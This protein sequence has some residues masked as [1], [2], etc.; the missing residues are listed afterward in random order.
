VAQGVAFAGRRRVGEDGGGPR[1]VGQAAAA[2]AAQ[3]P[4][5]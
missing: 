5:T 4:V 3:P 2:E 1:Q